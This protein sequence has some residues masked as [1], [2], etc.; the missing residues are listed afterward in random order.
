MVLSLH[1]NNIKKAFWLLL[2]LP[3]LCTSLNA[4]LRVQFRING[5]ASNLDDEDWGGD[6]S[7]P[8]WEYEIDDKLS[9]G[10]DD[11]DSRKIDDINCVGS[12]SHIDE[13]FSEEYDCHLPSSFD[14]V[15]R[16]SEYDR[17]GSNDADMHGL[18]AVCT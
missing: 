4:Q 18:S 9:G 15:F 13:F 6:K 10:F 14:F 16:G 1:N 8:K 5:I 2:L 3:L 17:I 7:D 11:N 12:R